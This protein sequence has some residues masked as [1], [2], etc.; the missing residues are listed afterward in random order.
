MTFKIEPWQHQLE[1]IERARYRRDYALFFEQG[2]GKTATA[3]HILRGKFAHAERVLRTIIVTLPLPIPQWREEWL[4]HSKIDP[5]L[6]VPLYGSGKKRIQTFLKHAYDEDG[7]EK[8]CVF[9]TNYESLL[10]K[11]LFKAFQEWAPEALVF[12]ESHKCKSPSSARA[13]Q[14]FLLANPIQGEKPYTQI[15]TG[16]PILNKPMDLFQQFK[17]LD[18]G[19]SFGHNFFAFRAKY[20]RDRNAGM[21]KHKYF[22]KWEI[23][24]AEKDG[25]DAEKA[26]SHIMANKSMRVLKE[27]C[28]DLPP[29]V[30]QIVKV[31]MSR[32]QQRVY[33]E[34]KKDLVTYYDSKSC[35]VSL[36]I[37]KALRLMQ[38]ASGYIPL[39]NMDGEQVL[40]SLGGTPK[41][42]A[43][44]ELVEEICVE[45]GKKVLV[46]AVFRQN[47]EVIRKVFEHHNLKFV[48]VH[49][50]ISASKKR[51]NVESFKNDPEVVGFI[52]HPGSGGVGLNLTVAPYSIFYSRNFSLEHYLQA[53]ARNHRGGSRE[54]GH[55][56]I[57]HYDLVC[58]NT[59]E[60]VALKSL[61]NKEDIGEKLLS[62]IV[63]NLRKG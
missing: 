57:T 55:T 48:E 7:G 13:K 21:P 31:G 27:E 4:A 14:A 15:L 24:T 63:N 2:T 53:R 43:L 47:Y 46:W 26:I 8:P 29:E 22:P 42:E 52:G 9:I 44:S 16:T 11:D 61:A 60:E 5:K 58:E 18:G 34:L 54:A 36:A 19:L 30:S 17:I 10:M 59:I 25:F 28:L 62:E 50:D 32:E 40:K 41:E 35:Q 49:G 6:V 39:E 33:D 37:T 23:M 56:K 3:I 1:A 38:I 12:D 20:F 51:D 45:Q